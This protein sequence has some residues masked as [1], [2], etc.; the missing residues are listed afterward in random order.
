MAKNWLPDRILFFYTLRFLLIEGF[1]RLIRYMGIPEGRFDFL[2]IIY[3]DFSLLPVGWAN[4]LVV[5]LRR[6]VHRWILSCIWSDTMHWCK[7]VMS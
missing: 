2:I 4:L 6:C 5:I 7:V 1:V 3:W